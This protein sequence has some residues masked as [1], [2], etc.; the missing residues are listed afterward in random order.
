M[1]F[2]VFSA[3]LLCLWRATEMPFLALAAALLLCQFAAAGAWDAS[4]AWWALLVA[5]VLSW[6]SGL[7]YA[8]AAPGL[9]RRGAVAQ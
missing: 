7:D 2:I 9:F 4:A 5:L 8:R 3:L 1:H 6:I